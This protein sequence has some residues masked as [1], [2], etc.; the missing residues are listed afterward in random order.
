MA[1]LQESLAVAL[2]TEAIKPSELAKVIVDTTV[3]PKNVAFPTDAKLLHRAR[4]HLVRLAK[5]LGVPLRQS[6]CRVGKSALIQY[7]RYVHAKQFKRARKLLRKLKTHLRR[8]LRDIG[9]KI[10]GDEM[11]AAIFAQP[12]SRAWRVLR[13]K[14][15]QDA[16]K[17]YSMHAPEVAC[18]GKG[19]AHKPYEF[20]VKVSIAT[21]I[22]QSKGGRFIVHAKALPGNPYDGHTLASVLPAIEAVTG[23]P[24]KRIIADAGYKGRN[25]PP[26]HR[27]KVYIQGR[28][29]A[30]TVQIKRLL[31]RRAAVEPV[32]GHGK[33]EHRM[34]RNYLAHAEGDAA[35][36][37]LA[38]VGYNFRRLIRWL[39]RLLR[40]VLLWLASLLEPANA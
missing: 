12:L 34:D 19:K 8:V 32:I 13:Q 29:R 1:L 16:P 31:R 25:A 30:M 35:N 23:A 24:L 40:F 7:Q 4:E 33:N 2:K 15:R 10:D 27:F 6:Y 38:A 9:R 11:L 20:G 3:Q 5:Q 14:K 36:A 17:I 28:K 37:V 21:T 18:I 22:G 26:E 39:D